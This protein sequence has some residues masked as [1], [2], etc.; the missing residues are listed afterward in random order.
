MGSHMV[1]SPLILRVFIS[2][3]GDV[4]EER[5]LAR[6]VME[7]LERGHLLRGKVRFDIVAWDD[8]H[9][10]VPMDARETPQDSVTRYI[11]RPSDCDLTLV[12]LWSRIGTRLP[13]HV[14][15]PDGS[16]Y[17]SGTVW[18]YEDALAGNKPV[19][20][21]RRSAKP[22]IDLDDPDIEAKRAQYG[23][24]KSFF[25]G[26]TDSDGS[27]R[28]G[29]NDYADPT[30][31]STLLREHLE[32]F[33]D[34]RLSAQILTLFD[35][36]GRK[37]RQLHG[38]AAVIGPHL[39]PVKVGVDTR[40]LIAVGASAPHSFVYCANV[41]LRNDPS[42]CHPTAEASSVLGQITF[43]DQGVPV[44]TINTARWGDT[45]QP[46]I[47]KAKDPFAS[48]IDLN[49]VPFRIGET[50]ELNVAIKH[51]DQAYFYAFDNGTYDHPNWENPAFRLEGDTYQVIVRLRGVHLDQEH[52][53]KLRNLGAGAGL[54]FSLDVA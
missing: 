43:L 15:R 49:T 38:P 22:Q 44:L 13:P 24:V 48:L 11:G 10:A 6:E 3:P 26:L 54:E 37:D 8:G 47:R 20:L 50:H 34:E 40:V 12:I 21:Y 35:E 25:S 39:V 4:A 42:G 23:A 30:A 53:F 27:L 36:L 5:R 18:E 32:A 52:R 14:S 9:A 29:V 16:P 7:K 28:A 46:A 45:D 19:F 51:P 2:S 17:P 31:F 33:V 41:L 1:A